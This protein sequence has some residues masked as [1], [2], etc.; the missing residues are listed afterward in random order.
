MFLLQGAFS[1]NRFLSIGWN[2]RFFFFFLLSFP[3]DFGS[4][5]RDVEYK[6]KGAEDKR[7]S[8]PYHDPEFYRQKAAAAEPRGD[9]K[10]SGFSPFPCG[11]FLVGC[12]KLNVHFSFLELQQRKA[13]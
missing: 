10:E 8:N 12:V 7:A 9:K 13:T 3:K 2:F 5:F 6:K 11:D 1:C 4:S